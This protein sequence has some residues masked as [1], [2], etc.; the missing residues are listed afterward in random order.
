MV[1]VYVLSDG[2]DDIL[3]IGNLLNYVLDSDENS[4]LGFEDDFEGDDE[5]ID[6][7]EL[8]IFNVMLKINGEVLV[9]RKRKKIDFSK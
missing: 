9:K 4:F 3:V 8:I 5:E 2:E 6:I 1:E 7:D